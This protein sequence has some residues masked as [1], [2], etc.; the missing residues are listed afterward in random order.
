MK[1]KRS[2]SLEK[3]LEEE[4]QN[5]YFE[6]KEKEQKKLR[7]KLW[8]YCENNWKDDVFRLLDEEKVD[9]NSTC[10]LYACAIW[11]SLDLARLLIE[12][13]ADVN[14]G[15]KDGVA[16]GLYPLR[17]AV[18]RRYPKFV[19]L[20]IEAK[21]DVNTEC[22]HGYTPLSMAIESGVDSRPSYHIARMLIN[23]GA[24]V[25]NRR[26]DMRA[27]RDSKKRVHDNNKWNNRHENFIPEEDIERDVQ[28]ADLLEQTARSQIHSA[29]TSA[30]EMAE[31]SFIWG[32][33]AKLAIDYI[34]FENTAYPEH[35]IASSSEVL[36]QLE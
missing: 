21:A 4:W 1:R 9:V 25:L 27:L 28:I 18:C 15:V 36:D 24:T 6:A 20:L 33:L 19:E 26:G 29:V 16:D 32:D 7:E 34:D 11:N 13:K 14:Y 3:D 8:T 10:T 31:S 5:A 22:S 2:A 17:S 30:L 12:R 23:A 35:L